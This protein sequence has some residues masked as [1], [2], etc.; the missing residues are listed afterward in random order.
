MNKEMIFEPD[1]IYTILHALDIYEE[2]ALPSIVEDQYEEEY[3]RVVEI[4]EFLNKILDRKT[5]D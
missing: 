4:R 1:R 2:Q 3:A 5:D